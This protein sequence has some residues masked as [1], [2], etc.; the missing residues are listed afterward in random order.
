VVHV[1]NLSR[2]LEPALQAAHA[3]RAGLPVVCTP[4]YQDLREYNR[5]GRH[6]AGRAVYRWLRE[7]DA[8]L[9]DARAL[10]NLLRAG[11]QHLGRHARLAGDLARSALQDGGLAVQLQRQVLT[12]CAAVVYNSASEAETLHRLLQPPA[13]PLEAIVP[14]SIDPDEFSA[15]DRGQFRQ[16]LG[17]DRYVLC[18]ARIED[19]KNQLG[20]VRA[21]A[22]DSCPLVLV[23]AVN[24]HH[25]GY[26][27]EV[28]RAAKQRG[29]TLLLPPL[30][31]PQLLSAMAGAAAHVLPSWFETA[32]LVSLEAA[33]AG[34]PV[35]S[36]DR[37]YTRAVLGEEAHYCDPGDGRSIGDAVR[38]AVRAGP[39]PALRRRALAHSHLAAAAALA[40]IYGRVAA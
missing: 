36:T 18:V 24:P 7:S 37:G 23:G 21:L 2:P 17:L 20:L 34:C 38:H 35:V 16:R 28:R 5:R 4:I 39:S 30:P 15:L 3:R 27:A 1:F 11:P 31:R 10:V 29:R 32:G 25:R 40:E 12:Q 13:L 6:G 9:E 8:R 14:V 26:L 19:L 33:A 22:D